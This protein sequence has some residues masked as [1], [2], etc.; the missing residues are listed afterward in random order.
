MG[1]ANESRS[2]HANCS[3]VFNLA[4]GPN[5]AGQRKAWVFTFLINACKMRSTVRV[6]QTFRLWSWKVNFMQNYR[7]TEREGTLGSFHL[8][9]PDTQST[10]H[11]MGWHLHLSHNVQ[12]SGNG[13]PIAINLWYQFVTRVKFLIHIPGSTVSFLLYCWVT[14][15]VYILC[16]ATQYTHLDR[17]TLGCDWQPCKERLGHR[18]CQQHMDWCTFCFCRMC[19]LDNRH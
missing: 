16:E 18:V 5:P 15:V 11:T 12:A 1:V 9:G 10:S 19:N 14:Y 7:G 3:V 2:A 8:I 13:C 6:N 17:C 4:V